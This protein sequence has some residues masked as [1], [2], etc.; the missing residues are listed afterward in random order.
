MSGSFQDPKPG[1]F[2]SVQPSLSSAPPLALGPVPLG[3]Q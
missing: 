1:P 2:P 3:L